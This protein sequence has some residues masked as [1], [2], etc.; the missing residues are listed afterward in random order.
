MKISEIMTKEVISLSVDDTVERAAQ[1]MREYNIGSIP[2]NTEGRGVV[3]IITDRDIILRCVAEGKDTK[4]QNIREIM[5][6]NPVVG[7]ENIDVNDAT[8]IMGERQIRRL[9]I[10]SNSEL[11]G[12]VSLGDLAL[13]PNLKQETTDVL[14]EI[15]I[16]CSHC[17]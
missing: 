6:S 14:G 9:P 7:D 17:F 3:G 13:E 4:I 1:I 11:I 10:T 12:I 5:T 16:P 15:S 2:V 8:R